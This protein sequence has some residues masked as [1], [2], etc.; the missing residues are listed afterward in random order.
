MADGV[1]MG[2]VVGAAT[3]EGT[4]DTSVVRTNSDVHILVAFLD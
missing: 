4:N 1:I 2:R 3:R